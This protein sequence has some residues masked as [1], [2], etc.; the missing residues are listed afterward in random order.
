M[1][2]PSS[3]G[4]ECTEGAVLV[5]NGAGVSSPFVYNDAVESPVDWFLGTLS[6]MIWA[7]MVLKTRKKDDNACLV[8]GQGDNAQPAN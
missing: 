4:I 5:A 6:D 7:G 8:N 3:E 1:M 2:S